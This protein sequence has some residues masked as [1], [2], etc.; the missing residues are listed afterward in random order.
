[1][2]GEEGIREKRT[3]LLFPQHD[4]R[5]QSEHALLSRASV[6][7]RKTGAPVRIE[8]NEQTRKAVRAWIREAIC[9]SIRHADQTLGA[10]WCSAV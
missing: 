9:K 8:L 4:E 10:L 3:K 6:M 2:I 7:Q 5:K 1:M